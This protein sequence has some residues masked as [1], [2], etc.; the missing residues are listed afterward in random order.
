MR[1]HDGRW[2]VTFNGEIYN[3][4]E[5]RKELQVAWRG[6][7]DTETLVECL[8][9]WGLERTLPRLNGM[10]AFGALD[11]IA[12]KLYLVRDPFGVKPLYYALAD[13]GGLAFSSEVKA[14]L[15]LANNAPPPLKQL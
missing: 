3:H 9:A 10:F 5:L 7:S 8:S 6:H 12:E 1:S 15:P 13:D 4:L 11:V 2:W 14:L